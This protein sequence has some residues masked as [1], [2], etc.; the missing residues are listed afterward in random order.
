[1]VFAG[2]LVNRGYADEEW[3]EWFRA[4]GF[5][6][7]TVPSLPASW[8]HEYAGYQTVWGETVAGRLS[9]SWQPQF[10][11]PENGARGIT[12]ESNYFL[13]YQNL[14]LVVRNSSE[15]LKAQAGWLDEVLREDPLPWTVVVHH[16]PV[17]SSAGN[18]DNLDLRK[19]WEPVY[20]R[21]RVDLVLQGH[22]HTY[23][24]G[25]KRREASTGEA[26]AGEETG[27]VYVNSVSGPKMYPFKPTGWDSYPVRLDGRAEG[28]E[29]FQVVEV[30]GDTLRFR[31]YA[32]TVELVDGFDLVK[33]PGGITRLI[34]RSPRLP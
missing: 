11:L 6:L 32:P 10:T 33:G 28:I 23:A 12:P 8:N 21:H 30:D 4:A 27:T 25:S 14:P 22:D 2:D 15:D 31:A 1:M 29:L 34:D 26:D 18:R 20:E 19:A 24:R 9:V 13:D 17:Y 7:A 16:F 3:G 5:E